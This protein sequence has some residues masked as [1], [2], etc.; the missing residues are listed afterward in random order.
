MYNVEG[1]SIRPVFPP[2][3]TSTD[4]FLTM[5]SQPGRHRFWQE[6]V[7]MTNEDLCTRIRTASEDSHVLLRQIVR[8]D[9]RHSDGVL[10][11]SWERR[12]QNT[13]VQQQEVSI[14]DCWCIWTKRA[15]EKRNIYVSMCWNHAFIT[16]IIL[17]LLSLLLY[18]SYAFFCG[19]SCR[20]TP[21][22]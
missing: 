19:L 6:A 11:W 10:R 1:V 13:N 4:V 16:I 17:L 5:C 18:Y 7:R 2:R 14:K 20:N 9:G 22:R 12:R 3:K 21:I 15:S 8:A